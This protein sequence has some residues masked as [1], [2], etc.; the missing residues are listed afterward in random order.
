MASLP[1]ARG[2]MFLV[3]AHVAR[4]MER[5]RRRGSGER[6]AEGRQIA[7]L[8]ELQDGLTLQLPDAF[9][10]E[11]ELAA[12]LLQRAGRPAVDAV[13]DPE[14][15]LLAGMQRV[16]Q[17][18]EPLA[19]RLLPRRRARAGRARVAD[20]LADGVLLA[21]LQRFVQRHRA[22]RELDEGP[23]GR[24]RESRLLGRGLDA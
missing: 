5:E 4:G 16:E 21:V 3:E 20:Q 14:D 23:G 24:V 10:A 13:A 6:V 2:R 17:T 19:D 22:S 7:A 18:V 11:M 1:G 9:A 15:L 8:L 12:E